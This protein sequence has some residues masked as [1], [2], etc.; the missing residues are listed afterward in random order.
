MF[1]V[2]YTDNDWSDLNSKKGSEE[3]F[4]SNSRKTFNRFTTEQNRTER[5]CTGNS[6]H[7][8]ESTA[9]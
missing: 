8:T 6:T 4:I 9:V 5:S 1:S 2:T 7:N 3:K